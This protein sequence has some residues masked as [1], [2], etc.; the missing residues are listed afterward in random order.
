MLG[1]SAVV[2][3]AFIVGCGH[4]GF[5]VGTHPG[6]VANSAIA[7][8]ADATMHLHTWIYADH[9]QPAPDWQAVAQYLDYAMV[10]QSVPDK[11]LAAA[12]AAAGIDVVEYTNPNRQ[13]QIGPPHFPNNLP[14]DYAHDC[15][16][17]RIYRVGYG[18]ATPPP[19]PAPTPTD[20]A[21]Y[22]MDPHSVNVAA[23]WA[24][25][26]TSFW[27]Q[28]GI[29]PTFVFE[30]TADSVDSVKPRDPCN[31]AQPDWTNATNAMGQTMLSAAAAVGE[32]VAI[33]YNGLASPLHPSPT[34]MPD[35]IGMNAAS[36]GGMAENCYSRQ[37]ASTA[38]DPDPAP[39]PEKDAQWLETEGVEIAMTAAQKI[40]VCNANSDHAQDAD[41]RAS[42]RLYVIASFLLTYDPNTSVLDEQFRPASGF[43][44][45]PESQIVA[46]DPIGVPPLQIADLAIRG[47]FA[48]QYGTCFVKGA[49]IGPCATVVNPSSTTAFPFP[50]AGGYAGTLRLV[51]GGVLD[52]GARVKLT[53]TLPSTMNPRSAVIA[54]GAPAPSPS[55][56]SSPSP[57]PSDSP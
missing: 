8:R 37:P 17:D 28:A 12:I 38:L 14:S 45:F 21:M 26:V 2:A 13:V 42:L 39:Y 35:A 52:A 34:H 24:A 56:S 29:A 43:P 3:A 20:H 46:L 49:P 7:H 22:L 6:G 27:Q 48:R 10:G 23:S 47:V 50:F 33:V 44:V 57:S 31:Y 36:A 4:F 40:F 51:G 9:A 19:G 53:T 25:E 16:G 1:I 32:D 5:L 54:Y 15:K 30:D 55:P 11:P 41:Q 18:V